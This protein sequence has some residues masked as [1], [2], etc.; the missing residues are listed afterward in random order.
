MTRLP[1]ALVCGAA[2][3]A[4][5][6]LGSSSATS[7]TTA[8]ARTGTVSGLVGIDGGGQTASNGGVAELRTVKAA[9]VVITGRTSAGRRLV[10]RLTTDARGRFRLRLPAGRYRITARIFPVAPVQPHRIVVVIAGRTVAVTI[11]G[12][13]I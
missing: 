6:C 13:V 7:T 8:A 4:A 11:K 5:G 10:H 12:L 9:P 2:L 1:F 3:F